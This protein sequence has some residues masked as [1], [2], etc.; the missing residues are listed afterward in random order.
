MIIESKLIR[1]I[2]WENRKYWAAYTSYV[3]AEPRLQ[4]QILFFYIFIELFF[5]YSYK[6]MFPLMF[7]VQICAISIAIVSMYGK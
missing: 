3:P 4:K 6:Y 1:G 2:L 7:Y 5:T